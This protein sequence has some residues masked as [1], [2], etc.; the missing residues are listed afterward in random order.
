M[1]SRSRRRSKMNKSKQTDEVLVR[2]NKCSQ[3]LAECDS[4]KE[5]KRIADI[6]EAARIYAQR[7]GM[8]QEAVILAEEF[9]ERAILRLGQLRPPEA[10]PK[11]TRGQLI[12]P[13]VIGTNRAQAPINAP[14]N[15]ELGISDRI[16]AHATRLASMAMAR[17]EQAVA[18]WKD[19]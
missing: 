3:L 12:G 10:M 19:A 18:Q 14:T 13:G 9:R 2:L 1:A 16:S 11:G 5:A 17:F 6:S 8:S 7:S 4:V 15:D